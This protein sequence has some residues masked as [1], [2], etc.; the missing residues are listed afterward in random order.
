MTHKN[1]VTNNERFA[2]PGRTLA[3]N[4]SLKLFSNLGIAKKLWLVNGFALV[5]MLI[6]AVVLTQ[7]KRSAMEDEKRFNTQH[8]VQVAHS[9][10]QHYYQL[11]AQG[12]MS[13][14]EAKQAAIATLRSLRYGNQDYLWIN[15]MR[16]FVVM[17]PM[18]PEL[19]GKDASSI[20]DPDGKA[21]FVRFVDVVK[22]KGSGHVDYLWP[23]P[24]FQT[25][26]GKVSFV[27]GFAPWGWVIGTG[28]YT[29]D[30]E[31]ALRTDLM[32]MSLVIA[33]LATCF[34]LLG[35]WIARA[36]T[37]PLR[38]ALQLAQSVAAGDLTSR[39]KV[40]STDETGELLQ[41]LNDMGQSLAGVVGEVRAGAESITSASRQ[42]AAGNTDLSQ[43][44]EEQ[45]SS[46]EETASSM[47]ELTSTVRQNADN[48]RQAN[49][50]AA[51][52]SAVAVKGGQVVAQVVDTMSSINASSRKIVDII[53]VIDG[54]A[55][56]TNILALNA[57]VEAARAGEQ[58]RGFA[59]VASEVRSLAQRSAAA[60]KEIKGLI[61]DSVA[62]VDNGT[63]QVGE[64]GK[65]MDEIVSSVKRVTD[66]MA[67]IAA[68]SQ[69]QSSGIEQVNQAVTKMDEATQ[70]N[71]ALV[72]QVAAATNSLAGQVTVVT[73]ALGAFRLSDASATTSKAGKVL[74]MP[75]REPGQPGLKAGGYDLG[76]NG[77]RPKGRIKAASASC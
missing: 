45:A 48:A 1:D 25:P 9:T 35:G 55:F 39:V 32:R 63:R 57:A 71:A 24:G 29:D 18:K 72:E 54:I 65:T 70:R 58:G 31:A 15:D 52:A 11:S 12:A 76:H 34:V 17:H 26:V 53:S 8:I 19:D 16:P 10:V 60:A 66:I 64:A 68:A 47:E 21:L 5:C 6:V 37:A 28:I 23:K 61:T 49:Q 40:T 51:G 33:A 56:Q 38:Q 73:D 67:E 59:V 74:R 75:V 14:A 2:E 44:T 50:L 62:K 7:S 22:A 36:V 77:Q 20:K 46:L 27:Q 41:A 3:Q 4:N 69:E 13:E 30:I 42:I 43:R